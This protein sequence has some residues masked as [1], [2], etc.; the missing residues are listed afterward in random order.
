ML[1]VEGTENEINR[2]CTDG[3]LPLHIAVANG[4]IK[5]TLILLREGTSPDAA[6]REGN[7][8]LHMCAR[9]KNIEMARVILAAGAKLGLQNKAKET[10]LSIAKLANDASRRFFEGISSKLTK[11]DS[12]HSLLA[13]HLPELCDG[14]SSASVPEQPKKSEM[15][16]AEMEEIAFLKG[17]AKSLH[18][19]LKR[20][21][22]M[23]LFDELP[24]PSIKDENALAVPEVVNPVFRSLCADIDA[25]D[26]KVRLLMESQEIP[27][28]E[29]VREPEPELK[30]DTPVTIEIQHDPASIL[31]IRALC[32]SCGSSSACL[33]C[34]EC[35]SRL[36]RLCYYSSLHR[37][38]MKN[39]VK[40]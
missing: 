37:C 7:T 24:A 10:P 29:P 19:H 14:E 16:S 9:S 3:S 40:K 33:L 25:I 35:A 20:Y 18:K 13:Q 28:A 15:S 2:T 22:Q 36:C 30:P 4:N 23:G 5:N 31:P 26:A 8:P 11:R 12:F 21:E 6:N 34:K 1:R 27:I 17:E 32:Q 39:E 38:A